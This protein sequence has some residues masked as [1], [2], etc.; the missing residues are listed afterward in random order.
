MEFLSIPGM[1][2]I[3]L[4]ALAMWAYGKIRF[5]EGLDHGVIKGSLLTAELAMN[6]FKEKKII[7]SDNDGNVYRLN[8]H[9]ERGETIMSPM[10]KFGL[11]KRRNLA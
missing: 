2:L 11:D 1:I 4:I 5:M 10:R 7:E 9:G 3:S 8:D 6:F